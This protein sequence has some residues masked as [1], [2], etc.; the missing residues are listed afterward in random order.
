VFFRTKPSKSLG[1]PVNDC[2][3]IS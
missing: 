1:G 3:L 2:K